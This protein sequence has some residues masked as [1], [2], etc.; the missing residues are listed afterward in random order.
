MDWWGPFLT[1]MP[2]FKWTPLANPWDIQDL[3]HFGSIGCV[4][5]HDVDAS[6]LLLRDCTVEVDPIMW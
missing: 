5:S 2:S 3:F 1:G 4:G 6:N